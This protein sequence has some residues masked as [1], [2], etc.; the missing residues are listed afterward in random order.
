LRLALQ[1]SHATADEATNDMSTTETTQMNTTAFAVRELDHRSADGI[2]VRLLWCPRDGRVLVAVN[3]AK[4]G[5][6]FT[7]TVRRHERALDVFHHPFSYTS[8]RRDDESRM[9]A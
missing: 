3:D 9:A 1:S 2:D 4:T 8:E 5:E 7:L 6:A